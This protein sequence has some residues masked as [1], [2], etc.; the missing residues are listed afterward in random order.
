MTAPDDPWMTAVAVLKLSTRLIDEIQAGVRQAGFDDVTPLHG[1]A[2]AR[3]AIGDATTAG[4]ASHLGVTKQAAAQLVDRLVRGGY[5][6]RHAHPVDRRAR[7]LELTGRGIAC[8]TA[9]RRAAERAI[10]QWRLEMPAGDRERFEASVR[11]LTAGVSAYRVP[12]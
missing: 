11:T 7:L 10:G 6:E 1:F 3:I 12:L 2:F 9:A 4:L 8:M 5:V